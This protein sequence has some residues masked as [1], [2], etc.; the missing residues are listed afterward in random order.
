MLFMFI[1][2]SMASLRCVTSGKPEQ[3]DGRNHLVSAGLLFYP[4]L[5]SVNNVV[6]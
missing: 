5:G 6:E 3:Y 1:L 4:N 2:N